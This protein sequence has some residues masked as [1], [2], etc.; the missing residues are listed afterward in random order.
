MVDITKL[1]DELRDWRGGTDSEFHLRV[2][3][4]DALEILQAKIDELNEDRELEG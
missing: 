1:I 4:A 2:R 3:A